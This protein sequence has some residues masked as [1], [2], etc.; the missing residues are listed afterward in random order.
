VTLTHK[1]TKCLGTPLTGYN[2]IGHSFC[3]I[4]RSFFFR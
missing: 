4:V 2:L 1:I 3:R